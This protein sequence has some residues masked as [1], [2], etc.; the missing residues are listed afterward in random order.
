MVEEMC[1]EKFPLMKWGLSRGF[2]VHRPGSESTVIA[3]IFIIGNVILQKIL[4]WFYLISA[5]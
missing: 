1:A 2:S 4:E 5:Y 3:F